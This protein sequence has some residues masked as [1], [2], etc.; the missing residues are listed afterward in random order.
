M[1]LKLTTC[2]TLSYSFIVLMLMLPVMGWGQVSITNGSPSVTIDFSNTTPTSVGSNPTSAFNGSGFEANPT[3]AGRLNSNAWAVTGWSDGAL[4]FGGTRNTANTDYTRG[5]ASAAVTTGGIYAYTGS[6]QSASNPCI[7]I[8][9]GGSDWAPGT[10]TL[11]IQN[12]GTTNITELTIS[13]NL[14][15]RNDQPRSNSFN[16][17]HSSDDVTYTSVSAL[18]YTSIAASDMLGWVLVGTSPSRSTTITG[19]N[20]APAGFYYIR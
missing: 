10:L 14:Y 2:H 4:T 5:S 3:T 9:P 15:V 6:P 7:M 1:K 8:Q 20:I 17:A 16:F 11:R 18:D 13:Y 19:L 12:N